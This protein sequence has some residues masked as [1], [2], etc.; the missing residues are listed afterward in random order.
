MLGDY[1]RPDYSKGAFYKEYLPVIMM[2][3]GLTFSFDRAIF[4]SL[5][6]KSG[7][8]ER[9]PSHSISANSLVSK[10][11]NAFTAPALAP[12]FA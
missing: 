12:A 10:V 3:A 8:D 11:R 2:V 6:C 5:I 9:Y 4:D 1:W 7:W